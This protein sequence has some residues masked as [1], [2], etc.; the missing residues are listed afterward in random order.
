VVEAV[1]L[2]IRAALQDR[3]FRY[4]HDL[5]APSELPSTIIAY[6]VQQARWT[7]GAT[8]CLTKYGRKIWHDPAT[9]Y[10]ARV[11]ALLSLSAYLTNVL[12]LVLLLVQWPM[13]ILGVRPPGWLYL[14]GLAGLGQPLLF[15]LAQVHIHNDWPKRLKHFPTLLTVAIGISP[16]NTQALIQALLRRNFTFSRTPKGSGTSYTLAPNRMLLVELA[17]FAYSLGALLNAIS[18]GN[19]RPV[20][21]LG[22][23]LIGFG[24]VIFSTLRRQSG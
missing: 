4:A 10:T 23:A 18:I 22:S 16:S 13:M 6:K 19:P 3:R 17:F 12:V 8:Q 9:P 2:S 14:I 24:Y 20:L 11:Y 5:V 7:L 15:L 1:C 21:F